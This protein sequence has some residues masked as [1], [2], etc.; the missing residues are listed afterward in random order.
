MNDEVLFYKVK[1]LN[2]VSNRNVLEPHICESV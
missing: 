2:Q 1:K